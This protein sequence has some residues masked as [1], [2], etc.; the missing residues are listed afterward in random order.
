MTIIPDNS[1]VNRKNLHIA[2]LSKNNLIKN[3]GSKVYN[4]NNS[5][6]STNPII[7]W[8]YPN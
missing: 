2:F 3:M 5:I 6:L 8:F 4:L 7:T 1:F